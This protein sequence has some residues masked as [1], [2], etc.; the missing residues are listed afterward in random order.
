MDEVFAK[1]SE[2]RELGIAIV[3]VEQNARRALALAD[4][5]YVLELGR[6]RYTGTGASCSTTRRWRSSTSAARQRRARP[7]RPPAS[8]T[9]DGVGGGF[10]EAAAVPERRHRPRKVMIL[11]VVILP[12]PYFQ[13][14]K[15]AEPGSPFWSQSAGPQAPS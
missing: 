7:R 15:T 11:E 8:E 10:L 12:P 3:I 1:L 4:R 5:G 13:I 2:I 6:N 14:S 9:G